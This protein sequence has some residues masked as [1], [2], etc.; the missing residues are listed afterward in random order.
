MIEEGSSRWR[1]ISFDDVIRIKPYILENEYVDTVTD[2]DGV[3]RRGSYGELS[4]KNDP[5]VSNIFKQIVNKSEEMHVVTA[6]IKSKKESFFPFISDVQIEE[7]ND[8][9]KDIN[10][11]CKLFFVCGLEK[12]FNAD[13]V[14]KIVLKKIDKGHHVGV[15]GS[16]L[17][18]RA[19]NEKI[20]RKLNNKKSQ[21]TIIDM[22]LIVI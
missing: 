2:Y 12:I 15:F 4:W 14:G 19:L 10:P 13:V 7:M 1:R 18:D 5:I 3:W 21:I 16:S 9:V 8:Y 11:S 22:G 6:R 20:H 17:R